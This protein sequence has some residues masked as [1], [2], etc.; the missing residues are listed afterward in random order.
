MKTYRH[1]LSH[2]ADFL[3]EWEYFN[4]NTHFTLS[5]F[6]LFIYYYFYYLLFIYL[7]IYLFENRAAVKYSRSEE[8]T[9]II[10]GMRISRWVPTATDTHF[11]NM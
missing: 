7:F 6:I 2:L 10:W 4:Q 9:Q 3:L 11:P 5:N 8:R 1:F